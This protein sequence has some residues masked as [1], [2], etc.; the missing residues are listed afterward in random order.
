MKKLKLISGILIILA[1]FSIPLFSM[2][3]IR[4]LLVLAASLC[5]AGAMAFGAWLLA[6]WND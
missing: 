4:Y 2:N 6:T 3:P 1:V 5:I